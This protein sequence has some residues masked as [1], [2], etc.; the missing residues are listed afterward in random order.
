MCDF[1]MGSK[2]V[3]FLHSRPSYIGHFIKQ[4]MSKFTFGE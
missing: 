4:P 3:A 1:Y 2:K